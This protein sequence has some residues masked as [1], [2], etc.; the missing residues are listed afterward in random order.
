MVP[1]KQQLI[2][3][4]LQVGNG[5]GRNGKVSMVVGVMLLSAVVAVS[6]SYFTG[7]LAISRDLGDRPLRTEVE[8]KINRAQTL[9]KEYTDAQQKAIM[10]ELTSLQGNVTT[11]Q[12][13]LNQVLLQLRN[14]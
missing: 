2:S 4:P 11:L 5:N 9:L 14:R 12:N 7:R 1:E 6:T 13:T 8:R 3:Q 10:R